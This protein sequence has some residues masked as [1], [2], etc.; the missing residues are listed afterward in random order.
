MGKMNYLRPQFKVQGRQT[1]QWN[2]KGADVADRWLSNYLSRR[3]L[4]QSEGWSPWREIPPPSVAA[5]G[6]RMWERQRTV[7]K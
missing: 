6:A 4:D 3:E 2:D 1:V 7:R 5:T